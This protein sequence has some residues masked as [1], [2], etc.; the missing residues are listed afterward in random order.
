MPKTYEICDRCGKKGVY[1]IHGWTLHPAGTRECRYCHKVYLPEED[2]E[3][4][5]HT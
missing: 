5:P 1:E 2:A 4:N 3:K